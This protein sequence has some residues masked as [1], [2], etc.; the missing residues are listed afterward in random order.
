MEIGSEV[1]P[2]AEH[3]RW[4]GVGEG[5]ASLKEQRFS[6][7]HLTLREPEQSKLLPSQID[8]DLNTGSTTGNFLKVSEPQYPH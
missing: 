6:G 3:S 7:E 4:L 8:M 1:G 2:E 5:K